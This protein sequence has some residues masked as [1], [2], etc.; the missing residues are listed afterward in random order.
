VAL[1]AK[2]LAA[3]GVSLPLFY[4][5]WIVFVGTFS[6]HELIVGIVAAFLAVMGLMVVSLRYP[7][8]FSPR[9]A[10]LL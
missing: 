5:F 3:C 8:R 10:D 7:A 4:L 1:K 6:S 2:R 9:L